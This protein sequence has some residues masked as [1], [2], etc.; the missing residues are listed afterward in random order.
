MNHT[1]ITNASR[2]GMHLCSSTI[3]K[4]RWADIGAR[5]FKLLRSSYFHAEMLR[6]I[7]VRWC[8]LGHAATCL[9]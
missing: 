6:P 1:T 8:L 2:Y 3:I 5:S 7:P 4:R 9:V